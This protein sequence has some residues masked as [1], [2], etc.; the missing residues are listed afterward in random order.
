MPFTAEGVTPTIIINPHAIPKRRTIGHVLETAVAKAGAYHGVISDGTAFSEVTVESIRDRLAE[1]GYPGHCKEDMYCGFSGEK[2]QAQVAIGPVFYQR[3]KHLVDEKIHCLTAEHDVLTDDGWIPIYNVTKDHKVATL[4]PK[5]NSVEYTYPTNIHHYEDHLVDMY[6]LVTP[7]IELTVTKG[8]RMWTS[9][10]GDKFGFKLAKDIIGSHVYYA[11]FHGSIRVDHTSQDVFERTYVSDENVYCISVPNE[12][13]Y[14]RKNGK[15][16]WTG[17][18]RAKGPY[19]LWTRQPLEGRAKGGGGRVGEMET[20]AFFAH[21]MSLTLK[22][23]FMECSDKSEFYVCGTCGMIAIGNDEDPENIHYE[24]KICDKTI[25]IYKIQIPYATK[26]WL[27]IMVM[28]GV[29]PRLRLQP[30]D[31]TIE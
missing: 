17:N 6:E 16:C 8:H 10:D 13:F 21:G 4:N 18:S 20:W 25:G 26:L 19:Q 23:R 1:T 7:D 14:V 28:M 11:N 2:F 9:I 12:I 29:A 5:T 30:D 31:L 15:P 24:C 22:E 3:L 27:Q